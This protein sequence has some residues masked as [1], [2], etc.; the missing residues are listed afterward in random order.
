MQSSLCWEIKK[1]KKKT[2]LSIHWRKED[3]DGTHKRDTIKTVVTVEQ[4]PRDT[5]KAPESACRHE[6]QAIV[7]SST[8]GHPQ[9]AWGPWRF[10]PAFYQKPSKDGEV[11]S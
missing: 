5:L 4:L 1:K 3:S 11:R 7:Q 6:N 8:K 2:N 10:C 9:K